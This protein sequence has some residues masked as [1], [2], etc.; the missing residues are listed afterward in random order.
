MIWDT[1]RAKV[2]PAFADRIDTI[3]GS[4][5]AVQGFRSPEKQSAYWQEGRAA[6]GTIVHPDLVVTNAKRFQSPHTVTA[7]LGDSTG[8][9]DAR[10]VDL[11]RVDEHGNRVWDYT[12]PAWAALWAFVDAAPGMHG[13]WH[14]PPAPGRPNGDQD[15]IQDTAWTAERQALMQSGQWAA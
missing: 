5:A 8:E 14:F 15:H 12:H 1:D 2:N 6:D 10:A 3:P 13:G 11:A 7:P 4:W 9:P